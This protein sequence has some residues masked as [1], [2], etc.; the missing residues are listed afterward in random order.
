MDN[1]YKNIV[2]DGERYFSKHMIV[3]AQNLNKDKV[4]EE[5]MGKFLVNVAKRSHMEPMGDPIVKNQGDDM[6]DSVVGVLFT[7]C[8]LLAAHVN[9]YSNKL[10]LDVNANQMFN[11]SHIIEGI[12]NFFG[13]EQ[14]QYEVIFRD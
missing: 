7:N 14:V 1:K 13:T 4:N 5:N 12:E 10:H 11:E 6:A 3:T 8:N 2:V 9:K